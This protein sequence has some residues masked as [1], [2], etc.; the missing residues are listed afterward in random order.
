MTVKHQITDLTA[1]MAE[2]ARY[3]KCPAD[4]RGALLMLMKWLRSDNRD[5]IEWAQVTN[6]AQGE[7]LDWYAWIREAD[8]RPLVDCGG[9]TGL[10]LAELFILAGNRNV[11]GAA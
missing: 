3:G 11:R 8:T 6:Y 4:V 5:F 7:W 1:A 2:A 9:L 10:E